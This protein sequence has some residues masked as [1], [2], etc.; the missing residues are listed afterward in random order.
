MPSGC[1]VCDQPTPASAAFCSSCGYPTALSL[2][3]IR[4]LSEGD[5]VAA[6]PPERGAEAPPRRKAAR[7]SGPDPQEELCQ[8][9]AAETDANLAILQELGGDTLDVS[10]DLRQA[11]LSEADGRVVEALDILRR[12][13][14]RVVDQSEQLF[15]RRLLDLEQRDATLARSGVGTAVPEATSKMRELFRSGHRLE[16]IALLKSNDQSLGRI[17]GDWKGLQGLLKQVESLR[18]AIRETGGPIEEVDADI[19]SVRQLLQG[20]GVTVA[21]LDE[22]S[23]T[24]ARAVM[25]MHEALPSAL[26]SELARHDAALTKLPDGH[27]AVRNG[28]HLHAEAVRHLRRGRLPE[29]SDALRQLRA[30]MKELEAAPPPAPAAT[31]PAAPK[32]AESSDQFLNRLLVK[33]RGLAAR[34][35]TLPPESEIAYEAA[36]EI[37]RATE[38]LRARQLD[39]AEATLGRLMRTLDAERPGEA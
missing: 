25:V 29:A 19:A 11:A 30:A 7:P 27:S 12:A 28:R 1:P 36:A 4:A 2:D 26:E 16:A 8:K 34:V 38:L 9:I 37:R 32:A 39:E 35:R 6:T 31:K 3:A 21:A 15:A 23:Q 14:G 17:E 33:A 10:S 18:E 13:L 24:A 20:P 5:P 22:A